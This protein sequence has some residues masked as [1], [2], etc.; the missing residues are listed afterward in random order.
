M[1]YDV[2]LQL[3]VVFVEESTK[4]DWIPSI[5]YHSNT[6]ELVKL[7]YYYIMLVFPI[8]RFQVKKIY[9]IQFSNI[10][11]V[12]FSKAF[13][14]SLSSQNQKSILNQRLNKYSNSGNKSLCNYVNKSDNWSIQ[15]LALDWDEVP[16]Y[17]MFKHNIINYFQFY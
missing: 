2:S 11:V 12:D 10:T 3:V 9:C 6:M 4:Y 8:Y 5:V 1:F 7:D 14:D 16:W 13:D 17:F 15:E